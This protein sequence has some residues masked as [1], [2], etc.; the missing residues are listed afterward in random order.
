MKN[1]FNNILNKLNRYSNLI[2]FFAFLAALG[3]LI[4]GIYTY[5]LTMKGADFEIF[6]S[7]L[8]TTGYPSL[9]E[10]EVYDQLEA[11]KI[12]SNKNELKLDKD[13]TQGSIDN[14]FK[15]DS[16]F[17]Q[18]LCFTIVNKGVMSSKNVFVRL[19]FSNLYL[20][21]KDSENQKDE[22]YTCWDIQRNPVCHREI[23]GLKHEYDE[24][25]SFYPEDSKNLCID[26]VKNYE[27]WIDKDGGTI[28]V[29][30]VGEN[31]ILKSETF[32]I[33]LDN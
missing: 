29:S 25:T 10:D 20:I 11:R 16:W 23:I 2:A 13:T 6:I 28:E 30:V 7:S 21:E 32:S 1:I 31:R 24:N 14:F 19:K 26:L 9:R 18:F 3:S 27:L 17:D 5:N 4:V 12:Y 15:T 8:D 22:F 33:K